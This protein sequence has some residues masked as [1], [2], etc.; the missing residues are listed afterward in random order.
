MNLKGCK[1][2]KMKETDVLAVANLESA[3]FSAPWPEKEIR[4]EIGENP[5][6]KVYV[7]LSKTGDVI[8]YIDFMITFD[9]ATVSRLAVASGYRRQ[10][11]AQA[12]LDEMV[13]VCK[14]QRE[15][16][17]WITLEVRGSN[18]PARKLYKKN[19]WD[20]ITVKKS[21]YDDGEDAIY[22]VRSIIV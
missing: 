2:R 4:Y 11:I 5:C 6:A 15:P 1:V 7:A 3:C 21:Y 22:M 17:E 13:I 12:L 19:G 14:K 16:V 20:E 8:G 9:S 10:G 18:G